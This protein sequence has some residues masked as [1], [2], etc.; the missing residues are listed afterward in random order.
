MRRAP[1]S[2]TRSGVP[3]V[4]LAAALGGCAASTDDTAGTDAPLRIVLDQPSSG[5]FVE[6]RV[7]RVAGHVE[8]PARTVVIDGEAVDLDDQGRFDFRRDVEPGAHRV[9]LRASGGGDE[10]GTYAAAIVGDL[11]PSTERVTNAAAIELG[12][13]ALAAIG[14]GASDLIGRQDVSALL[15]GRNPVVEGTWGH[16]NVTSLEHGPI[17]VS[18]RPD[19][20][21][22]VVDVAIQALRIGLQVDTSITGAGSGELTAMSARLSAPLAIGMT[23]GHPDVALS[24]ATVGF[25]GF[26]FALDGI[27]EVLENSNIVRDAL[28]VQLEERL[29]G[30]LA[31]MMPPYLQQ[32][33]ATL[34]TSG[35]LDVAGAPIA[36]DARIATLSVTPNGLSATVD[37]GVRAAAPLPGRETFGTLR[38]D[39]GA[40]PVF[41]PHGVGL[42]VAVDAV[43]AAATAAWAAGKL[44]LDLPRVPFGERELTAGALSL[45]TNRVGRELGPEVPLSL[46]V[47]PGLPPVA[48]VAEGGI[49]IH[50]ADVPL[51]M[52]ADTGDGAPMHLISLSA[53]VRVTIVPRVVDGAIGVEIRGLEIVMDPIDARVAEVEA[54]EDIVHGVLLPRLAG[55]L[56]LGGLRIPS[57][58]GFTIDAQHLS[59]TAGYAQFQ[60]AITYRPEAPAAE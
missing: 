42:A 28:R 45:I 7:L 16:V 20:G 37:L 15:A 14:A 11:R 5:A 23:E 58:R 3:I 6:G 26:A 12:P 38:T 44:N 9:S 31:T 36:Y 59:A 27:P 35:E 46:A 53:G 60:G 56:D 34:P 51:D 43:N 32:T 8:G 1:H 17:E 57:L 18:F 52:M 4:L 25:D 54:L 41:A 19:R 40:P 48:R 33:L 13:D 24:G 2:F 10:V 22:L 50:L 30:M 55:M 47:R 49:E 21:T 29:S 39:R